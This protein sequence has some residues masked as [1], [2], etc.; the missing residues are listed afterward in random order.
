MCLDLFL[1]KFALGVVCVALCLYFA[2]SPRLEKLRES[3]NQFEFLHAENKIWLLA[4][5]YEDTPIQIY[6]IFYDQK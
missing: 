3:I 1:H 6:W 5:H 4:Y 2:S